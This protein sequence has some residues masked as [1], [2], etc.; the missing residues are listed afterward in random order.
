LKL[1]IANGTIEGRVGLLAKDAVIP[2]GGARVYLLLRPL[3]VDSV[4]RKVIEKHGTYI[5]HLAHM[6]LDIVISSPETQQKLSYARTR[7]EEDGSF[8]FTD[9]PPD[10]WYY[11]TAQALTEQVMVSWQIGVY[12]REAERVQVI[13]TNTNAALPVY[14]PANLQLERQVR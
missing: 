7:T 3:D 13:L 12:L 5:P 2:C 8:L 4:K 11:V 1:A 14:M 10:R 9:L 6:Y